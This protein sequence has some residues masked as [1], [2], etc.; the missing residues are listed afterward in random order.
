MQS[1]YTV[2]ATIPIGQA[3]IAEVVDNGHASP[4]NAL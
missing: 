3:A 2:I 1:S 4:S